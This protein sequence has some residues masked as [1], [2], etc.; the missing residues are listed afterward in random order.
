MSEKLT[1]KYIYNDL[2][3]KLSQEF[4]N[5][6]AKNI[7]T[8]AIHLHIPVNTRP[9]NFGTFTEYNINGVGNELYNAIIIYIQNW[10]LTQHRNRTD[11][12]DLF[13]NK[14]LDP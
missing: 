5:S 8:R 1:L 10:Q 11:S 2:E 7:I 12:V 14:N 4:N 6:V 9:E 3:Y 13:F